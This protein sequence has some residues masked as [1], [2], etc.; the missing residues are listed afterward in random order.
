MKQ[1]RVK[2]RKLIILSVYMTFF[3]ETEVK[4]LK[5][6]TEREGITLTAILLFLRV[7]VIKFRQFSQDSYELLHI[8]WSTI[9]H[10]ILLAFVMLRR[11]GPV[12]MYLIT[13]VRELQ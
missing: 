10:A 2:K 4:K 9:L 3:L 1:A 11:D 12:D 6:I 7:H 13:C 8:Y 5:L